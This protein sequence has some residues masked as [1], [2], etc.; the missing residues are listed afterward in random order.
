MFLSA[1]IIS[2]GANWEL[3]IGVTCWHQQGRICQRGTALVLL[4]SQPCKVQGFAQHPWI[5]HK[6]AEKTLEEVVRTNRRGCS[7]K[8]TTAASQGL[9]ISRNLQPAAHRVFSTSWTALDPT[10]F[11]RC[12]LG[13]QPAPD[14]TKTQKF[15]TP[16][17]DC[18]V[19]VA[20]SQK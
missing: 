15:A 11:Q 3:E 18:S 7:R 12:G 4:Q 5:I 20:V 14:K 2:R 17:K 9:P 16:P 8:S 13:K 1:S 6:S 10:L 19:P